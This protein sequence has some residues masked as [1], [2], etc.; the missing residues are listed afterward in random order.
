MDLLG[1]QHWIDFHFHYDFDVRARGMQGLIIL[2]PDAKGA[3]PALASLLSNLA[4]GNTAAFA[5]I[6]IGPSSVPALEIALTNSNEHAR[7]EAAQALGA[8]GEPSSVSNLLMVLKDPD[9]MTRISVVMALERFPK[10][11][12]VIVPALTNCLDDPNYEVQ[13]NVARLLG[14][15]GPDAMAAFPKLLEMV[16]GTNYQVSEAATLALMEID[17]DRTVATF[18]NNL[19]SPDVNVRR[20]TAW[21]AR[22]FQSEGEPAV[23]FLVKCLKDSDTKVREYAAVALREIAADPDLV[24]PG[25]IANLDDPDPEV[26]DVTAI[27]LGGFGA[28]AKPAVPQILKIIEENKGDELRAEGLYNALRD[29]DPQ[30]AAKLNGK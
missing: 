12:N 10:Q 30:A 26:R 17:F 3:I 13:G 2:G 4:D 6:L 25:L 27:A 24:V 28:R 16:V 14:S 19:K 8:L 5:L 22:Y 20:S 11:A 18:T 21:A 15:F 1:R 7:Y 23:P 9:W 29:I